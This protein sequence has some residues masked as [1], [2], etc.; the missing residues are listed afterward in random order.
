MMDQLLA[1]SRS[2][3]MTVSEQCTVSVI[4][5]E[6]EFNLLEQSWNDLLEEA[7]VTVFQTF[8]WQRTWWKYYGKGK[9][10]YCLVFELGGRVVGI[11]PMFREDITLAGIRVA[12]RLQ[13]IGAGISDY[14]QPIISIPHEATVLG[15]FIRHLRAA[16]ASWDVLDIRDVSER[17]SLL[18]TLPPLLEYSSID[19][20]TYRGNECPQADLPET[21]EQFVRRLSSN[22]RH[23]L[24][25]KTER[26][27]KYFQWEVEVFRDPG[28]DLA[29]AVGEFVKLHGQRWKSFGYPSAFDEEHCRLF[30]QEVAR[31]LA[32]RGWLRLLFLKVNGDRVATS[33]DFNFRD[34]IYVYLS[35]AHAPAGVMKLSPAFI[36]R[37][38]AIRQ[39]IVEGMKTYDFLR[40]NEDYKYQEF[41]CVRKENWC[42]RAI[43]PSASAQIRFPIF[44]AGEFLVRS[45]KRLQKEFYD[46][47]RFRISQHPSIIEAIRYALCRLRAVIRI[48]FT[49]ASRPPAACR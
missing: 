10:L 8:E 38:S 21:W 43:S 35:H 45:R 40:G 37:C 5:K 41:H 2:A 17:F 27:Q 36:L 14:L 7:D 28:D 9:K 12:T 13:F 4:E 3:T 26:L 44:L 20:R 48:G 11:A 33:F 31:K 19:V 49:S 47:K 32:L 24:K 16:S 25:R 15:A 22:M 34:R 18:K 1:S 29:G 23:N 30:H 6:C 42:I 39:G 46:F